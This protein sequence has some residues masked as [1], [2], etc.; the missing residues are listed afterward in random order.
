MVKNPIQ[1]ILREAALSAGRQA[2]DNVDAPE[3]PRPEQDAPAHRHRAIWI[4][5]VHLGTRHT[6]VNALLEFLRNN[7]S[8]YLYIVGDF[9][10]G[11]ELR[12]K[13]RWLEEYNVLIQK[14]LR[15]SRKNVKITFVVGN[16]DEFLEDFVGMEFGR[17]RIVRD[18][19]HTTADRKR[20]LVLHGHQ[21]DGMV[22]CKPWLEK[23]GS[24]LYQ[25]ILD[26][27][28]VFNRVRRR[29]GFGYWSVAAWLKMKAKSAVNYVND[30]EGA[31][32]QMARRRRATGVICGHIHRAEMKPIGDMIYM[33]SGDWIE[34]CTALVEDDQGRFRL[35]KFH[36]QTG[37]TESIG[38]VQTEFK[39]L[40]NHENAVCSA[41]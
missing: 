35:L 23:L 18:C 3:A 11:W 12:R 17:V 29:F 10:D 14:I 32:I 39:E 13:W 1:Q 25:R 19:V 7:A 24:A 34:S 4:S 33:N 40:Q 41:G 36:E 5:D 2:S 9:I 26:F 6:Q 37:A 16:H 31:M 38:T 20:I 15:K 21:I 8:R 30:F 27:N 28:Y 22:Q